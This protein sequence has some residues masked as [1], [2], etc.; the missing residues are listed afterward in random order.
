MNNFIQRFADKIKGF[1]DG[2]DRIVFK[3]SIRNLMCAAGATG[4][5]QISL[6]T[7]DS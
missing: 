3:G 7:L 1:I 5:F 2:F 4:F 6:F